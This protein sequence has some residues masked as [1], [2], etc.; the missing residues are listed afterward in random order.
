MQ[1]TPVRDGS[2]MRV[3]IDYELPKGWVSYWLGFVFGRFYAKWCI[4]RMLEGAVEEFATRYPAA[5]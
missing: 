4:D 5:A 3:F 2:R 1:P